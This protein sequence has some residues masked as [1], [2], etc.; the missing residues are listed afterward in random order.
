M[1]VR[2][3]AEISAFAMPTVAAPLNGTCEYT[4]REEWVL[5]PAA[6]FGLGASH[7]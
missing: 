1:K 2:V 3:E 7:D 4:V 6:M 5:P